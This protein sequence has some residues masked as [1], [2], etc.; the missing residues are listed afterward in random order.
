[1]MNLR[2]HLSVTQ[3]PYTVAEFEITATAIKK[4]DPT[5][6]FDGVFTVSNN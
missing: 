6:N 1:M 3:A 2:G 4:I 5:S